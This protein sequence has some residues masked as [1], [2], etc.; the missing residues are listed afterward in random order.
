MIRS[1]ALV[2]TS[3]PCS[4]TSHV[5][6]H[7]EAHPSRG[8]ACR[9]RRLDGWR[10]DFERHRLPDRDR[11]LTFHDGAPGELHAHGVRAGESGWKAS[12][13]CRPASAPSTSTTAPASGV[14][15]RRAPWSPAAAH[16][17]EYPMTRPAATSGDVGL[18]ARGRAVVI[19]NLDAVLR[20][21]APR[22]G[23]HAPGLA[24][25]RHAGPVGM[26]RQHDLASRRGAGAHFAGEREADVEGLAE[27]DEREKP[28]DAEHVARQGR[29]ALARSAASIARAA[30]RPARVVAP[31]RASGSSARVRAVR[32][33]L[34]ERQRGPIAATVGPRACG[35]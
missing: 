35:P 18:D 16:G 24:V 21:R 31:G 5:E 32:A 6:G 23:R 29:I 4:M 3:R 34:R 17:R 9:R 26:R 28:E 13:A 12:A 10:I 1:L 11:D 2:P 7:V 20:P 14:S 27:D 25:D 22:P 30:A 15:T 8:G 33:G 19:G